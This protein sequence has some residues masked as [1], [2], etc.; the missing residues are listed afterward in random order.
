MKL[1]VEGEQHDQRDQEAR[2]D[3]ED[4]VVSHSGFS[5]LRRRRRVGGAQQGEDTQP[6]GEDHDDF[7][8]GIDGPVARQHGGHHVR[9]AHVVVR[10]VDVIRRHVGLDRVVRR[11]EFG[12]GHARPR[13]GTHR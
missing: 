13:A 8:E 7:P 2:N 6:G 11:A 12:E 9:N 10:F 4:A 1:D 3:A 5:S